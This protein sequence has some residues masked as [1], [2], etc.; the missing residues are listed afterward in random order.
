MGPCVIHSLKAKEYYLERDPIT[1]PA[2]NNKNATWY[3]GGLAVL[4]LK[5]GER[6]IPKD[7]CFVVQGKNLE[8]RQLVQLTHADSNRT[9]HRAGLDFSFGHPKSLSICEHVL[10]FKSQIIQNARH[11]A[12]ERVIGRIDRNYIYYR[13]TM[14]G[15]TTM[16]LSPGE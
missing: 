10:N 9:A 15:A 5:E 16:H 11:E 2:G 1:N 13:L 7:F 6:V 12:L 8:G 3:G 14:N 4:G